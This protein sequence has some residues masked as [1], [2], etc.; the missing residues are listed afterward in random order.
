MRVAIIIVLLA[1]LIA[2]GV[3]A[4]EGLMVPNAPVP[5][6]G[7]VAFTVGV[8]VLAVVGVGLMGLL[9]YSSRHGYDEPP[10]IKR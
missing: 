6:Y 9:F 1:F 5:T 10:H 4:Y 7:V 3:Y 2:V 8:V